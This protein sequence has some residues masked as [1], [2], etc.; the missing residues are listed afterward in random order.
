MKDLDLLSQTTLFSR[1]GMR[2]LKA[3][4]RVCTE[5]RF[6]TG[7]L[8]VEQ[9]N[10]GVGMFLIMEGR[11]AVEKTLRDQSVV[12][13]TENGP[14][15]VIGEMSVLDGALRSASVRA[16]E[17]VRCLVL[18]AW[19]FKS[20]M[21]RHPEVALG[22]LPVVVQRFRENNDRFLELSGGHRS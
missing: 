4:L 8:L 3:I 17:P 6:E 2:H 12:R 19:S 5:R 22:V 21:E 14:G 20:L 10:P 15:Q 9:G 13:I 18:A 7:Q 1:L 11:V 16:L